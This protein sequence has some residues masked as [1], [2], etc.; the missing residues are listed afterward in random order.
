MRNDHLG[1][2]VAMKEGNIIVA[3]ASGKQIGKIPGPNVRADG[4][5]GTLARGYWWVSKSENLMAGP[6]TTR[7]KA[8]EAARMSRVHRYMKE[9]EEKESS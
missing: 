9:L 3:Y 5:G 8:E 1:T 7:R 2:T 4:K 6:F